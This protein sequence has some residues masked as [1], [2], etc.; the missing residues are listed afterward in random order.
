MH[1]GYYKT[2]S[3]RQSFSEEYGGWLGCLYLS[4]S[5]IDHRLTATTCIEPPLW[6]HSVH[7]ARLPILGTSITEIRR[8]A[9]APLQQ[10]L[11]ATRLTLGNVATG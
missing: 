5:D 11:S 9:F 10:A 8:S 2:Q 7:L 4:V 1:S 6:P 3:L